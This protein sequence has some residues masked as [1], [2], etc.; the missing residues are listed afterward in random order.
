MELEN[1]GWNP[2]TLIAM[3]T[4]AVGI[5]QAYGMWKQFCTVSEKRSAE[6]IAFLP[7]VVSM[8]YFV[9]SFFYALLNT[10]IVQASTASLMFFLTLI[11]IWALDRFGNYKPVER[12]TFYLALAWAITT[13]LVEQGSGD[14]FFVISV[15][16]VSSSFLQP[17]KMFK[18][19]SAGSVNV[20]YYSLMGFGAMVWFAYAIAVRDWV[21]TIMCP[22]F[23]ANHL[24][25]IYL[26]RR[27]RRPVDHL[28][29][30]VPA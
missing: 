26:Y 19:K 13:A 25:T 7:F 12:A 6:A 3:L 28:I 18:A 14:M 16:A 27:Y 24:C 1:F 30:L 4:L 9:S 22:I 2:A 8:A 17:L 5:L 20:R 15:V 11:L 10:R 29:V 21:G 23:A